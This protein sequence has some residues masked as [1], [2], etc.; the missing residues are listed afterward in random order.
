MNCG[1]C[2]S[3]LT[4]PLVFI[5]GNQSASVGEVAWDTRNCLLQQIR[6]LQMEA[7]D[8]GAH[9]QLS[10]PGGLADHHMVPTDFRL[11]PVPGKWAL[12]SVVHASP[13]LSQFSFSGGLRDPRSCI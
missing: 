11:L 5:G 4:P 12:M 1:M 3:F 7:E 9:W 10:R 6:K 13:V 2:I 8:E